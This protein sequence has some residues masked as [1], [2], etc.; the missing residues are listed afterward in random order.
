[1]TES[2][3]PAQGKELFRIHASRYKDVHDTNATSITTSTISLMALIMAPTLSLREEEVPRPQKETTQQHGCFRQTVGVEQDYGT[4]QLTSCN[5]RLVLGGVFKLSDA[6]SLLLLFIF[7]IL[8]QRLS[9]S[10]VSSWFPIG[11]LH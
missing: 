7:F 10:S 3:Q 6:H 4:C 8:T 5:C 1:M 11:S 2:P 9:V